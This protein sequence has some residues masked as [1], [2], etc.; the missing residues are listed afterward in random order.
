MAHAPTSADGTL[1]ADYLKA[2]PFSR[3]VFSRPVFSRRFLALSMALTPAGDRRLRRHPAVTSS[4]PA[5]LAPATKVPVT[6]LR[7]TSRE[8]RIG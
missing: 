7:S 1:L 8:F 5:R 3:A 2:V 6:L 4:A